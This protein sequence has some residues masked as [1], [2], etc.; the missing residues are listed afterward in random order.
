[1]RKIEFQIQK[2]SKINFANCMRL[3]L[4]LLFNALK[5]KDAEIVLMVENADIIAFLHFH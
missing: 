2:R 4:L 3:V 1:M 5:L